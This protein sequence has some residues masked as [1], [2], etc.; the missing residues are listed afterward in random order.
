MN[1][2]TMIKTRIEELQ[3][4]MSPLRNKLTKIESEELL[5]ARIKKSKGTYFKYRNNYSHDNRKW[6]VHTKVLE[7]TANYPAF[8]LL[9][10]EEE[11]NG[12]VS[13]QKVNSSDHLLELK[14]SKKEF[15]KAFNNALK[16]IKGDTK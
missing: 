10:V 8:K 9:R 4:Q 13:I 16:K 1:Q 5:E 2:K 7:V 11:P 3:K 14:S 15:E 6:W 12:E